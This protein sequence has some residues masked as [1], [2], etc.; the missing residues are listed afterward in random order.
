[1]KHCFCKATTYTV[2][3]GPRRCTLARLP[4]QDMSAI[5]SIL[6]RRTK[7][8]E[9]ES[10]TRRLI[11]LRL[12]YR[13]VLGHAVKREKK[14]HIFVINCCHTIRQ[15]THVELKSSS[16]IVH[17]EKILKSV[18]KHDPFSVIR[19]CSKMVNGFECQFY[20]TVCKTPLRRCDCEYIPI[21]ATNYNRQCTSS[22]YTQL[23]DDFKLLDQKSFFS[24]IWV[25]HLKWYWSIST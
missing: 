20:L 8:P 12:S 1:M 16:F 24:C 19:G 14:D 23:L 13:W 15:W 10:A 22:L 17:K 21:C 7:S 18:D 3:R 11:S 25:Q 6:K 5:Y 4:W 9:H 2:M